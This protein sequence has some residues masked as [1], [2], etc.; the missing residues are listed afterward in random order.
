[1]PPTDVVDTNPEPEGFPDYIPARI[2]EKFAALQAAVSFT[3]KLAELALAVTKPQDW[4]YFGERP[5]LCRS[6]SERIRN[7][8][9][10]TIKLQPDPLS[11]RKYTMFKDA[12]EKGD[13]MVVELAATV[14]HPLFGE[15]EVFGFATSRDKLLGQDGADSDGKPIWKPI[16]EVNLEHIKMKAYSNLW[17]NAI[18]RYCGLTPTKDDLEKK[19]GEGK[20]GKVGFREKEDKRT[21]ESVADDSKKGREIWAIVMTASEGDEKTA[22]LLLADITKF[23][24]KDGKDVPGVTDVNRLKGVRLDIALK[25]TRERWE[26]YLANNQDRAAFLKEILAKRLREAESAAA[27]A[28]AEGGAA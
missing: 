3:E 27:P 18:T 8:L 21:P 5:W 20:V 25:N 1:M 26:A 19:F 16:S 23:R 24:G 9:G 4:T 17:A 6:G 11:Q 14:S 28:P 22:R 2:E 13:Y 15:I 7:R 12:D 10:L